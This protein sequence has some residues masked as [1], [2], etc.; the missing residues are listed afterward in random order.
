[1]TIIYMDIVKAIKQIYI[2][3]QI[4]KC[5]YSKNVLDYYIIITYINVYVSVFSVVKYTYTLKDT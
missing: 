5:K 3:L 1:M 4:L 2:V